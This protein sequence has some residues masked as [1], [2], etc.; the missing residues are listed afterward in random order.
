MT[1][2]WS[3]LIFH[4]PLIVACGKLLLPVS[5]TLLCVMSYFLTYP[6]SSFL[7]SLPYVAFLSE[8][9]KA[10]T[11]LSSNSFSSRQE[12][13]ELTYQWLWPRSVC[14]HEGEGTLLALVLRPAAA[15]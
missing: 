14:A 5:S 7:L 1:D 3:H 11:K 10:D 13:S 6:V 9:S 8:H 2:P 12:G 4:S 15:W